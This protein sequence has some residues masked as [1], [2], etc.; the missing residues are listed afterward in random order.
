MS[1]S[2]VVRDHTGWVTRWPAGPARPADPVAQLRA[3]RTEAANGGGGDFVLWVEQVD[4]ALD[5]AARAEGLE[6]WRELL[7][8]RCA[9]PAAPTD[10]PTRAFVASDA[11][12]FLAVNNRAFA[13]HPEQGNMTLDELAAKQTEPWYDPDGFRI[14]DRD[15]RLA[16]F[17]WTKIHPANPSLGDPPLGDPP[18]GEIYVIAV[19]P[20]FHGQGLGKALTLAGL[21]WLSAHGMHHGML[22][23]EHDNVVAV[24]TY[25]R[26]GFHVHH[27]DRAYVKR[28]DTDHAAS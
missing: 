8:M 9:L 19:D 1:M 7:Q 18:L 24:R 27:I 2:L 17:C 16:A 4:D 22:Y 14:H 3:A 25:E 11:G 21:E 10:V 28:S 23:V 15:G 5:E 12:A 13:W 26:I 20:E 6:P